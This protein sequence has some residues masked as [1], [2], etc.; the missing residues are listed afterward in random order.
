MRACAVLGMQ[1]FAGVRSGYGIHR[2]NNFDTA[3]S[4]CLLLLRVLTGEDWQ[5]AMRDA[6]IEPPYCTSTE[7]VSPDT[8]VSSILVSGTLWVRLYRIL[9][10]FRNDMVSPDTRRSSR[11]RA[12]DHTHALVARFGALEGRGM[13]VKCEMLGVDIFSFSYVGRESLT[14]F[15]C[16]VSFATLID[17]WC[18]LVQAREVTGDE[19]MLGDCGSRYGS[20][21]FFDIFYLIG[22]NVLLNLFIAGE[23][24]CSQDFGC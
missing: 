23:C 6:G 12:C 13:K 10:L 8:L 4:G 22:N 16:A 19:T 21:F 7:M 11:A 24:L 14:E 1:L 20:L 2:R 5:T 17:T 18:S 9:A 15:V 3:L